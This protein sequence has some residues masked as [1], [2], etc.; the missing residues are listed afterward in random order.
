MQLFVATQ[1]SVCHWWFTAYRFF[2][3]DFAYRTLSRGKMFPTVVNLQ[4][5]MHSRGPTLTQEVHH[6]T[7]DAD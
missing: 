3:S 7:E 1:I 2:F 4:R 5:M 6:S